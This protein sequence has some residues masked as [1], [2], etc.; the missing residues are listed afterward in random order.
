MAHGDPERTV[1]AEHERLDNYVGTLTEQLRGLLRSFDRDTNIP[2]HTYTYKD[3]E[4]VA[5]Y[6][7]L[8]LI[9]RDLTPHLTMP[10]GEG[11]SQTAAYHEAL[12]EAIATIREYKADQLSGTSFIA[13][14]H[15]SLTSELPLDYPVLV[16]NKP[17]LA[18]RLLDRYRKLVG[19]L[20]TTHRVILEDKDEMLEELTDPH[21]AKKLGKKVVQEAGGVPR[22][23]GE[24]TSR[25]PQ[26][27]RPSRYSPTPEPIHYPIIEPSE[28]ESHPS[29]GFSDSE[30][31][32]ENSDGWRYDWN[33]STRQYAIPCYDTADDESESNPIGVA[34]FASDGMDHEVFNISSDEE[35]PM[36]AQDDVFP[37]ILSDEEEP[38]EEEPIEA[39]PAQEV[40]FDHSQCTTTT[41]FG[42]DGSSQ[43]MNA[44]EMRA[45]LANYVN[46]EGLF[47]GDT[48]VTETSDS[49]YIPSGRPYIP[50]AV[51][52]T[53]R[54][55]G[56]TPGR[57]RE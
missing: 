57:Y 1:W 44:E 50:E 20:Y 10:R 3:G 40:H 53:T 21:R 26:N 39:P 4:V 11:R 29:H 46:L 30:M 13:I 32:I 43:H 56:W 2:V 45:Y 36:E 38:M 33:P 47:L 37:N 6:R 8:I 31:P 19:A 16:K 7:V 5:K 27:S 25:Q 9:P 42:E 12:V 14:P 18:S 15:D 54:Q 41:C 49:D 34:G 22:S 23:P 24:G 48:P 28:P 35:E 51:R 52:R 17:G 55:H